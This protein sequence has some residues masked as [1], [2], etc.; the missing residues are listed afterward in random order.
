MKMIGIINDGRNEIKQPNRKNHGS[1]T[2]SIHPE[3][4]EIIKRGTAMKNDN[5]WTKN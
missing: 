1:Q 3:R 5:D 4:N 2:D